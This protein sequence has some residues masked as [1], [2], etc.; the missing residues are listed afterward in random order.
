MLG[1]VQVVNL[2]VLH[3]YQS[4]LLYLIGIHLNNYTLLIVPVTVVYINNNSSYEKNCVN[5]IEIDYVNK[6]T[7]FNLKF[8]VETIYVFKFLHYIWRKIFNNFPFHVLC[9]MSCYYFFY[10]YNY[11]YKKMSLQNTRLVLWFIC[12]TLTNF[13]F[14]WYCAIFWKI[15]I[16]VG[17][18]F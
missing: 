8:I 5:N 17:L 10:S 18:L 7:V 13:T 15:G 9:N 1:D 12:I 6:F 3:L 14:T 4:N 16:D 2:F 11:F